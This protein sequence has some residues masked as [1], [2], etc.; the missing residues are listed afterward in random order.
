MI[1]GG[2]GGANTKTGAIFEM[3]TDLRENLINAGIDLS[4]VVFCKQR[5]F[6]KM[7]KSHNF[8]MTENFGKEFWPDEAFIYDNQLF[9]IEKKYQ[10]VNGS[11]D[12]KIQTGPYKR[13]IY[14]V[15]ARAIGLKKSTYMYLL[16]DEAF[17][18]PKYTIHQI[19]YLK[20]NNIP[21]YF[22]NF[23]IDEIF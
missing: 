5:D 11:V 15:C 3:E 22:D 20:Q 1:A 4:K 23:P 17:N 19:P 18:R 13:I 16:K 9:V 10:C 8:D 21:V 14:D 12:E 7:M 2:T 6:P